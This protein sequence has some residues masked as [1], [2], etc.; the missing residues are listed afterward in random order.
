MA[1]YYGWTDEYIESLDA[2]TFVNY[3]NSCNIIQKQNLLMGISASISGMQN[4][5]DL[6]K[7]INKLNK[8][9]DSSF[10]QEISS[11]NAKYLA[12]EMLKNGN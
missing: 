11:V 8:E 5:S 1:Y 7:K 4:K 6:T 10:E 2:Q 12:E 3:S 9:I